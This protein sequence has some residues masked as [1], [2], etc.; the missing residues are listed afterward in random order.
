MP[1]VDSQARSRID[2]AVATLLTASAIV[3]PMAFGAAGIWP[4]CCLQ[5]TLASASI[6][7]VFNTIR[8]PWLTVAPLLC[9]GVLILQL[10]PIN[11]GLLV[12][13]AP[14]SLG[15]W[16]IAS[17]GL[18]DFAACVSINPA[19]TLA[20][21]GSLFLATAATV[22]VV[23][24]SRYQRPRRL[25][26]AGLGISG[27]LILATTI[28]ESQFPIANDWARFRQPG[29]HVS[30][31]SSPLIGHAESMGVGHD[32]WVEVGDRRYLAEYASLGEIVG[33]FSYP[34][35]L[36]AAVCLTIPIVIAW[37]VHLTANRLA[38]W[39]RWTGA[40]LLAGVA[41]WLVAEVARSR[42]GTG[43]LTLTLVVL[44]SAIG[45]FRWLRIICGIAATILAI[46]MFSF[47]VLVFM[48]FEPV[49]AFVPDQAREIATELLLAG[50]SEPAHVALR[51]FAA[52]PLLGTGLDTFQEIFP[53]FHSRGYTLFYAHNEYA[54]ILA[55]TGLLGAGLLCALVT[56]MVA[57]AIRFWK[58]APIPYRILN[59]GP[60]A[61]LAGIAAHSAFDWNFHLPAIAV[62]TVIVVGLC[63]A[64]VPESRAI[65]PV[66]GSWPAKFIQWAYVAA[67]V[68]AAAGLVRD[69]VSETIQLHLRKA[70]AD[71]RRVAKDHDPSPTKAALR[72]A[73]D[74]GTAIAPWDRR[75]AALLETLGKAY[76]HLAY[77]AP[78]GVERDVMISEADAWFRRTKAA[79]AMRRGLPQSAPNVTRN[80]TT[81]P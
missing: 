69:A 61:A 33:T 21:V 71:D 59:S 49:I 26:L 19:A 29:G 37:W 67:C 43:A 46:A 58:H 15:A 27:L 16:K 73:I 56:L 44:G 68:V 20:G 51:A 78:P 10:V 70:I 57:K 18:P 3:A 77:Q 47:L 80:T 23:D 36:A 35:H 12:N 14:V 48:P 2:L 13:L 62:L 28:V 22:V 55:E 54:Q 65:R 6:L 66:P 64:S 45:S 7:W 32:E 79:A 52:S 17:A 39:A 24:I 60:W 1:T 72:A 81:S 38:M 76:L 4:R 75:D 34:N 9:A 41:I 42:A 31:N 74:S 11:D 53:R 8:L 40:G 25:L 30:S 50:R 63:I 5:V